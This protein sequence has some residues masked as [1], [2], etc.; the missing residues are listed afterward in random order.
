VYRVNE[1]A[2]GILSVRGQRVEYTL[3]Q[4][5]TGQ[6]IWNGKL[7]KP[8]KAVRPGMYVLRASALDSAGNQSTP[9]PSAI[10]QVRYVT[11]ARKRVVVAPGRR[12]FMRVSA[13]A[14]TVRWQLHGR[15]G[16]ARAGTLR[17]RAPKKPGVYHLYVTAAGH[18][19]VAT[20]VV[21]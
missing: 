17:I 7:G 9:Y 5:S 14:P 13:D 15:S 10:V 12:F 16:V 2:H 3:G 8:A 4:K 20:V 19:A 1:P 6:L 11:L 18:S 21:G